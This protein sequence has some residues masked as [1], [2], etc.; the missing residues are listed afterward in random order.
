[1]SLLLDALRKA[2]RERRSGQPLNP[3]DE[4]PP[5]DTPRAEPRAAAVQPSKPAGSQRAL[6]A[7]LWGILIAV[8]LLALVVWQR[9]P[10]VGKAASE[11][12]APTPMPTAALAPAPSTAPATLDAA[13][14]PATLDR[15]ESAETPETP[16]TPET[17]YSLDAL[18]M[19]AL[20]PVDTP[21][22]ATVASVPALVVTEAAADEAA[23]APTPSS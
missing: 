17:L 18:A 21:P 20:Q 2:D 1:M 19:P 14:P 23:V 13:P 9:A 6:L 15:F 11:L 10:N 22:P 3:F 16:E 7:V 12:A 5:P 4:P 8:L